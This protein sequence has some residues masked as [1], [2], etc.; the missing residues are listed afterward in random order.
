M[1]FITSYIV[2]IK[3]MLPTILL[4]F[5]TEDELP[6][7]IV[8]DVWGQIFW[9]TIF[10]FALLFPMS[11]PR[12]INALR[13]TSFFGVLCSV[14]LSLAVFFVFY[15][16][17]S[18]VPDPKKNFEDAELFTVSDSLCLSQPN[19]THLFYLYFS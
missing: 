2:Y 1:G 5:W 3:S 18:L 16:D 7:F 12:S 9:A 8:S 19:L 14:Y 17:K 15:C 11:L 6:G 10:S 4:L 13:F